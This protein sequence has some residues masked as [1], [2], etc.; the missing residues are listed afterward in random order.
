MKNFAFPILL[1][2]SVFFVTILSSNT[3]NINSNYEE[4]LIA[5]GQKTYCRCGSKAE[6]TTYSFTVE[7]A[8]CCEG[9]PV[10]E[11]VET[12]WTDQ[13]GGV[14]SG[15]SDTKPSSDLQKECDC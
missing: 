1:I 12:T 6:G 3:L 13:G 2:V 7:Q 15:N 9:T 10:G 4:V 5:D 11:G 8:D 14:Y